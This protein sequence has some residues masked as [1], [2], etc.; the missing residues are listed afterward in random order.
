MSEYKIPI[1]SMIYNAA[2]GGHVTNSQQIIDEVLNKEQS[3][4]NVEQQELNKGILEEKEYTSGSN[5]GM[6]RVVLRKNIV[7]G[8]NTLTQSMINKSNTIYVIQYDFTL[9]ENI[10]VPANCILEFDG[11][12]LANGTLDGQFT[13]K[14][15]NY[16]IFKNINFVPNSVLLHNDFLRPEW[17]GAKGDCVISIEREPSKISGTDDSE[18]FSKCFSVANDVRVKKVKLQ[19]VT[20]YIGTGFEINQGDVLL[21]GVFASLREDASFY[22]KTVRTWNS[23]IRMNLTSCLYTDNANCIIHIVSS[24]DGTKLASQPIQIKYVNFL[25]N[26]NANNTG[27]GISFESNFTGPLWPFIVQYCH[28]ESFDKAMYFNWP[29]DDVTYYNIYKLIIQHCSFNINNWIIYFNCTNISDLDYEGSGAPSMKCLTW[30]FEFTDNF[31]HANTNCI[32]AFVRNG[33]CIISRNNFEGSLSYKATDVYKSER[34]SSTTKYQSYLML[35]S[36]VELYYEQNYAEASTKYPILIKGTNP[37]F[38]VIGNIF[39]NDSANRNRIAYAQTDKLFDDKLG[40]S[41]NKWQTDTSLFIYGTMW[42][43]IS[44]YNNTSIVPKIINGNDTVAITFYSNILSNKY[45]HDDC[46]RRG[47]II[48]QSSDEVINIGNA[49]EN[50]ASIKEDMPISATKGIFSIT[51]E[52][53]IVSGKTSL[54]VTDNHQDESIVRNNIGYGENE[55]L[56]KYVSVIVLQPL[57]TNRSYDYMFYFKNIKLKKMS[58]CILDATNIEYSTINLRNYM[59]IYDTK[60]INKGGTITD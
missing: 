24:Q 47:T 53:N 45:L 19:A 30:D 7:K 21:E 52:G 10:T 15:C 56:Y 14:D 43:S 51:I 36:N 1:P 26:P 29:V 58:L 40:L 41:I 18:A 49:N 42:G 35:Y 46:M 5:N 55:D 28:F 50:V 25:N 2:V 37:K 17:F 34:E 59:T 12:S 4:I 27:I 13:I 23:N 60:T 9:G 20:Y 11:G 54:I 8:V 32:L 31:C 44:I 3:V 16:H 57:V 38:N 39:Y 22:D 6:G 48:P 33:N